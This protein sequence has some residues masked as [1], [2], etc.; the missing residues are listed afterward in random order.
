MTNL[1]ND[2]SE[3]KKII[4]CPKEVDPVVWQY[5]NVRQFIL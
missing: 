5:E 3:V 2:P 1:G 4:E